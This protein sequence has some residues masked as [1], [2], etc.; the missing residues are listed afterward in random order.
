M[1]NG[2]K[3]FAAAFL[4]FVCMMPLRAFTQE[5][6]ISP[7]PGTWAN[8]Q[9]LVLNNDD[10]SDL[11]FAVISSEN[12]AALSN[13]PLTSGFV[14]D[15]PI[16]IDGTGT[17]SIHIVAVSN[18]GERS[19]FTVQYTVTPAPLQFSSESGTLFINNVSTNP[20]RKYTSGSSLII[21][22]E[23]KYSMGNGEFASLPGTTLTVA[24]LNRLERYVPCTVSDGKN[25][26]R[27]VIHTVAAQSTGTL[28]RDVPFVLHDWDTFTFTGKK[29]IYQIDDTFWTNDATPKTLDR[30]ISHTVRWQP[31]E[32]EFG[33][34]V[35]TCIIPPKPQLASRI[36][37]NGATVFSI[38]ASDADKS[39]FQL[40]P[41]PERSDSGTVSPGLSNEL[42]VDTFAGDTIGGSMCAGVYYDGVY[43]GMLS[44]PYSID[45][46]PP[47]VP[48][49][50]SSSLG[51]Y[52]RNKV[53]LTISS[54]P[55]TQVYFAVS[56][57]LESDTGFEG[58][59]KETFDAV[60][61]GA[62]K[63]Y[64]GEPVVLQSSHDKADFFKVSAYAM[65]A[66]GNKSA[67]SEYRVVVD[68]YNYYL[69]T[70][71]SKL[72][73][74]K[75]QGQPD[76]S[77]GNPFTT[78]A[79]AVKAINSMKFTQL[80]VSG[81]IM[82]EHGETKI[83]SS[84]RFIGNNSSI[85]IPQDGYITMQNATFEAENCV[86]QK[87]VQ[88]KKGRMYVTDEQ[89]TLFQKFFLFDGCNV[90]FT[91]CEVVGVFSF[92]GILMNVKNSSLTLSNCGLTIR[93]DSY[94]GAI[95]AENSKLSATQGRITCTADTCVCF[96][97][98]GGNL[99]LSGS[100]CRVIGHL[101]RV[102]EL[103]AAKATVTANNFTGEMDT[104]AKDVT[105]IWKDVDTVLVESDNETS[106][107]SL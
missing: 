70:A 102:A 90:S 81:T 96:S 51:S 30:S 52:A 43:Q 26:W 17:I 105:A 36:A 82:L 98:H 65:D 89:N 40:G 41:A 27:F 85:I 59:E 61:L 66:A 24:P 72:A 44:L 3:L 47:A 58:A 29:L 79:Q 67:V 4:S 5:D 31:V 7:A 21:P 83:T 35:E 19:D 8:Q 45:K 95:S 14:Y 63:L 88:N 11:Y 76:G 53:T 78:F 20:I 60:P 69:S 92:D 97:V 94:A 99:M 10:G 2:A 37:D 48:V 62:Y 87:E 50:A 39:K 86:F 9:A 84:C 16:I 22:A 80:H 64:H 33:N 103:I 68:E 55:E 25:F 15:G 42:T 46:Q 75:P 74:V 57:P 38:V 101:A 91:N 34:P 93:G 104:P 100:T 49:I 18:K 107:F 23:F 54:E 6:I 1:R 56:N 106:G 73:T 28:P 71:D 13:D 12:N 77:Y 32:Y